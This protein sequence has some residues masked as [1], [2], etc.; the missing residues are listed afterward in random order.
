MNY[1]WNAGSN[2][3]TASYTNINQQQLSV[4]KD[5][6]EKAAQNPDSV[7][8]QNKNVDSND[9]DDDSSSDDE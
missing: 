9:D 1:E 4:P 5:V 7:D 6:I 8:N 3:G 2:K